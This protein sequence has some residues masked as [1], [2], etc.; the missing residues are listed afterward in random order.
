M[1]LRGGHTTILLDNKKASDLGPIICVCYTNHTLDQGLERLVDEDVQ[2]VVRIGGSLKTERLADVNLRTV[3]QRLDFTN[4][5]T[6]DRYELTKKVEIEAKEINSILSQIGQLESETSLS[7]ALESWS[8]HDIERIHI[9]HCPN[10]VLLHLVE[11]W[12]GLRLMTPNTVTRHTHGLE[13]VDEAQVSNWSPSHTFE[14]GSS[15]MGHLA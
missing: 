2:N 5:E 15:V 13:A 10:Y 1:I 7:G 4:T 6:S 8:I 12:R 9:Y 14:V 3:V 11:D